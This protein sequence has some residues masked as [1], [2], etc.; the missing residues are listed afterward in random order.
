M[1]CACIVFTKKHVSEDARH[2][3]KQNKSLL[4]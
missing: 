1:L 4:W 2:N 3:L